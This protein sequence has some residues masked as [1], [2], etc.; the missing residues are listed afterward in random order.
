MIFTDGYIANPE[1]RPRSKKM[2]NL[3]WVIVDNTGWEAK[4]P[5]RHTYKINVSAE[6]FK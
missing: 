4:Y 6:Q 2:D 5:D 1:Q 3:C